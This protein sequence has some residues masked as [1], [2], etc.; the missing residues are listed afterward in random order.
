MDWIEIRDLRV[1]ARIGVTEEERA[2]PQ[3]LVI[4]LSIGLSSRKAG[5]TDDLSDTLDYEIVMRKVTEL[6][7]S[8]DV[9]LLERLAE[10]IAGLISH[11][12]GVDRVTV[13]LTKEEAPVSEDVGRVKVRIER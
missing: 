12:P 11:F 10:E 1:P 6:V 5:L 8:S 3:P 2:V 13:E 7:R 4:D 9:K